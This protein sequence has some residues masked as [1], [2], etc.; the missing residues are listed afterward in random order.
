MAVE[1]FKNILDILINSIALSYNPRLD[2]YIE[3]IIE[4]N[5]FDLLMKYFIEFEFNNIYQKLFEDIIVLLTNKY[6]PELL[7]KSFFIDNDFIKKF[8]DHAVNNNI[9]KYR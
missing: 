9:F 2:Q 5:I 8:I 4:L 1:Y 6:T 7:L 3:K